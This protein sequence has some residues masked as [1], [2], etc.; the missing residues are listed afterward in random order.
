MPIETFLKNIARF[1]VN[2]IIGLAFA[3]ALL[4]F[5]WGVFQFINS[6]TV[7]AKREDGKKKILFGIIGMFIMISAYGIIGLI[8][9]TFGITLD[10]YPFK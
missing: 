5:F 1:I 7:D 8:L 3:I 9:G 4:V 10:Y 6:E 2:P